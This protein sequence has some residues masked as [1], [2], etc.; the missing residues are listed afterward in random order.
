LAKIVGSS[1]M[2]S[3]FVADP[4]QGKVLQN[5]LEGPADHPDEVGI[6]L[7]QLLLTQGAGE[8][9]KNYGRL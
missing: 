2:L 9:L 4:A 3:G 5:Q 1:L 6:E 8:I 7:A